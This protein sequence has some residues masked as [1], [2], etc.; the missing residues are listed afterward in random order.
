[1]LHQPI[2]VH[3]GKTRERI[4]E[5]VY[6]RKMRSAENGSLGCARAD[7][8]PK[9]FGDIR[10]QERKVVPQWSTRVFQMCSSKHRL[11]SQ[12]S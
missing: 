6:E 2:R 1:M 7:S 10:K 9:R 11:C 5:Q 8:R 4:I 3:N 12:K